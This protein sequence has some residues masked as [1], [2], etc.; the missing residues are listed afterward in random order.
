[1]AVSRP[2]SSNRAAEPAAAERARTTAARNGPATLLPSEG[3]GRVNPVLHHVSDD[4]DALLLFAADHPLVAACRTAP[5]AGLP[6]MAELTDSA[7]V[8]LREPVRGLLWI[9]GWLLPLDAEQGRQA[10]LGIVERLPD[11]R[12]LDVGHGLDVLWLR[13]ASIVIADG[14][15]TASIPPDEFAAAQPDPFYALEAQ[16]LRHLE[17]SHPDVVGQLTRHVP[18]HV[19]RPGTR[20]RPL[21]LDRH[22]V[23]LRV[24]EPGGAD[25]DVRLRFSR[26]VHDLRELGQEIRRLLGCPFL[27]AQ[28]R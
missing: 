3:P 5:P 17:G 20:I 19:R 18:P 21:A 7:P 1:M 13:P 6:A 23:R 10:A 25:T 22:G 24:E 28:R 4:G 14:E 9:T 8:P 2:T 27:R 15:G 26:P 11:P 12:L 16:W